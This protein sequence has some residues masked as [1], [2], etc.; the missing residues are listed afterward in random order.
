M[1][2]NLL[3]EGPQSK[4]DQQILSESEYAEIPA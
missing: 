1:A 4:A 2:K 3:D